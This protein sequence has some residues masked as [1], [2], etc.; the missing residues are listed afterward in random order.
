MPDPAIPP[1]PPGSTPLRELA[2]AV[3]RALTLPGLATTRDELCYLRI[4]RD[5][6]RMVRKAMCDIIDD[7]EIEADPCD[8]MAVVV[9]LRDE[10]GQLADDVHDDAPVPSW[11]A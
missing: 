6:A 1:V 2:H 10:A 8:V 3:D 9:T 4:M 7:R 11:S 5:R